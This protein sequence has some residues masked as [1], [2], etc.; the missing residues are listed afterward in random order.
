MERFSFTLDNFVDDCIAITNNLTTV[1]LMV[2]A[3]E[4]KNLV[5]D[6][7]EMYANH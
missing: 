3:E 4:W 7:S 5:I 6:I 1:L 2:L